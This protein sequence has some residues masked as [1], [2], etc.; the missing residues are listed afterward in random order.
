MSSNIAQNRRM[1]IN[2]LVEW[3]A[4]AAIVSARVFA[5]ARSSETVAGICRNDDCSK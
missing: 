5:P 3:T 1:V 4:S 2:P